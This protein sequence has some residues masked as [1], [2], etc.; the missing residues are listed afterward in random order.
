MPLWD[1]T[2]IWSCG[3]ALLLVSRTLKKGLGVIIVMMLLRL[4]T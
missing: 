3:M 2:V 4:P 1:L